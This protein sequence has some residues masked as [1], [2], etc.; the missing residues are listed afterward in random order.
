MTQTIAKTAG[1]VLLAAPE[2]QGIDL[3]KALIAADVECMHAGNVETLI[4]LVKNVYPI[5]ILIDL[6]FSEDDCRQILTELAIVMEGRNLA[7]ILLAHLEDKD[8][9][10]ELLLSNVRD[11]VF[12][13]IHVEELIARIEFA[14]ER[15]RKGSVNCLDE[16]GH[17][18]VLAARKACHELN[19]PLQYIMG[20][21]QLALLDIAPNDPTYEMMNGI[22]QQSERMAQIAVNL[23]HLIRSI[24]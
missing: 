18:T 1:I 16:N 13:P 22:R 7:V 8:T 20:S 3:T 11:I 12:K 6:D 9:I 2:K 5:A 14:S 23:M 4:T 21:V 10:R 19:Q 24:S 17:N 15:L